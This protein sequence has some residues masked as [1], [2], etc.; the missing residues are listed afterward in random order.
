MNGDMGP[1]E[2][3]PRSIADEETK[4]RLLGDIRYGIPLSFHRFRLTVNRFQRAFMTYFSMENGR[5]AGKSKALAI[6]HLFT[7]DRPLIHG[8]F[9]GVGRP[10]AF[11][12]DGV[13][14]RAAILVVESLALSAVDWMEP[15]YELMTHPDLVLPS[16]EFLSPEDIMGRIAH[17][18]RFSGVMKGGPSFQGVPFIF[19]S[20]NAK[21]ALVEYIRLLD[22]RNLT[23]ISQQLSALSV[24]LLCA[25]HKPGHPAFDFYLGHL[26]TCINSTRIILN[27]LVEEDSHKIL[28]VRGVWLLMLLT[29]ITQLRPV[30]DGKLLVSK[31]WPNKEKGWETIYE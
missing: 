15:M 24:L 13:E 17:D 14:L 4:S 31:D 1:W 18:G 19:S 21:A 30:M 26:P 12:S 3:S 9:S 5:F 11:L 20:P 23:V 8:L 16:R 22:C 29:Y 10:L 2:A 6:S 25:T 28:L 7:G 27:D